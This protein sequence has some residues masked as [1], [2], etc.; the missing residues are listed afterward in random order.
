[1]ADTFPFIVTTPDDRSGDGKRRLVRSHVMRGK[2]LKRR[3]SRPPSCIS[4]HP[5][6]VN[7][8][9][10]RKDPS[11]LAGGCEVSYEIR[12]STDLDPHTLETMRQLRRAIGPPDLGLAENQS[13][14]SWLEP[15]KSDPACLHFT[16]F[17][18][19][20]W[21]DSIAVRG[22]Q[23]TISQASLVS[24]GKVLN[25]LQQ[26]F[27]DGASDVS[28][29]DSS[30]IVVTG[31]VMG[32]LAL[33]DFKTALNH[34]KGLHQMIVLRGGL[35][36]LNGNR[37]LQFKIC[38]ADISVALST[39]CDV[40]FLSDTEISWDSYIASLDSR[41]LYNSQETSTLSKELVV[42][43]PEKLFI[44]WDDLSEVVRA[45]NI[46]AQCAR[47][48]DFELYQEAMISIHYRL[49]KLEPELKIFDELIRLTLL[50]F[51]SGVFLQWRGVKF[52]FKH[53]AQQLMMILRHIGID[54][55]MSIGSFRMVLWSILVSAIS[56]LDEQE[57]ASLRPALKK[58]ARRMGMT[59]WSEIETI[60]K[61]FLWINNYHSAPAREFIETT[62]A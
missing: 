59:S 23:N 32:S 51:C 57:A 60:L 25:L 54:D 30:L 26:R 20:M 41:D 13:E 55:E 27:T 56:V 48:V 10:T 19:G 58:T 15:I 14:L 38:R 21:K 35:S 12:S 16:M 31:L 3:P 7:P 18:A 9:S 6:D 1:M 43:M 4:V 61:S 62:L 46:A 22:E 29:S 53:L 40:Y 52:R 42:G 24:Y 8:S 37:R 50:G 5:G 36:T 17:V 45:I 2:N 34:L 44:I 33:C 39:G 11:I 49:I 28:T 47:S